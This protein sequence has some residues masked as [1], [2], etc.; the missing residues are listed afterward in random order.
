LSD[1]SRTTRRSR[2]AH[3]VVGVACLVFL[4]LFCT[5]RL[6][7]AP[8]QPSP[9]PSAAPVA[10]PSP[11]GDAAATFASRAHGY[12]LAVPAGWQL[13][14]DRA[15]V[16]DI[17]PVRTAGL[18]LVG[19]YQVF[20]AAFYTTPEEWYQA[21]RKRYEDVQKSIHGFERIEFGALSPATLGGET[22]YRFDLASIFEGQ[23]GRILARFLFMPRRHGHG[24][25][26]H[27]LILLGEPGAFEQAATEIDWITTHFRWTRTGGHQ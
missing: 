2:L 12:E 17:R 18:R 1:P 4:V 20:E 5:H 11:A 6:T 3:H 10:L 21:A 14:P 7:A 19:W 15:G 25:D 16:A 9:A 26:V 24:V 8:T 13:I 22:A 27:E 23:S